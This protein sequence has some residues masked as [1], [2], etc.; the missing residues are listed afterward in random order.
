MPNLEVKLPGLQ[1]SV[2]AIFDGGA[3]VSIISY[4]LYMALDPLT[5]PKLLP[6][7]QRI[8][9]MWSDTHVPVGEIILP[10]TIPGLQCTIEYRFAVEMGVDVPLLL[11]SSFMAHAGISNH[12]GEHE[13]ERKGIRAR[14]ARHITRVV[15]CRRITL[16]NDWFIPPNSRT[17]VPGSVKDLK[18][19]DSEQDALWLVEPTTKPRE[20]CPILVSRSLCK[21][22]QVG[23]QIPVEV[24]NPT[25]EPMQLYRSTTIGLLQQVELAPGVKP[26]DVT[27]GNAPVEVRHTRQGDTPSDGGAETVSLPPELEEMIAECVNLG[28]ADTILFKDVVRRFRKLF[29]LKGEPLGR[30]HVTLHDVDTGDAKPIKCRARRTP[31]GLRDEAMKE[32]ARMLEQGVIEPSESPWASPVV[33]V[34]KKD[35]SLRYCVDYRKLNKVTKKDSYPLPNMQECLDSLG[36]AKYFSTMDLCSGYWQVGMTEAAKVKSA[37]YGVGG[38]L[39]QFRVMPFGLSNAPATFERLMERVLG[40]LQ[41]QICLCYIDDI[42]VYSSTISEHLSRLETVLSRLENANLKLKPKK[43]HFFQSKVTF[44][45]HVVSS[46]GISTDPA[47]V[48]KVLNC[49]APTNVHELRSL[50]GFLS[51]YRRFIPQFTELAKPLIA[52]T[53]KD[54]RFSWGP[55]QEK[56]F[57]K[58]KQALC[59]APVLAYPQADSPFMLDTDASDVG[60]GAVLSQVQ[61]GEERVIAYG[62]RVLTKAERN[63]CVTR[64][65]LLAVVHFTNHYRHFLLGRR[66][67]VRTDNSAVRNMNAMAYEPVGQI[68]R[69]LE[70]LQSFDFVAEHRPG[71]QH[72]NADGMSRPPFVRCADCSL[73]HPGAKVTKRGNPTQIS[74][75]TPVE[76]RRIRT[77]SSHAGLGPEKMGANMPQGASPTQKRESTQKV[78]KAPRVVATAPR[79][80]AEEGSQPGQGILKKARDSR[81]KDSGKK[82]EARKRQSH[83]VQVVQG[84]L[85]RPRGGAALAANSWLSGGVTL[86][87]A[88]LAGEQL[89]DPAAVDARIW[90]QSGTK[91]ARADIMSTSLDHKFLWTN[92]EVLTVVDDV[93]T[94]SIKPKVSGPEQQSAYVPPS[95]RRQVISLCHDTVTSGHF[96]YWKTLHLVKRYFIW[97]GMRKDIQVYCQGCHTCATKKQAGN[98]QRAPMKRYD[99]GLPMEEICIDLK[100]PYPESERGNKYVLVVVDSFTKWMEAYPIPNAE[101][102]TVAEKLVMEFIARFGVPFWIKSDQGRQFQSELFEEMCKLLG[103]EH[104]TSTA[105][106]PQGNSRVERM[107]KVVGNLLSAFC[108]SQKTW[109]DNLPLLTLAYNCT[110]H[111]V[112]GFS[113][114]YMT[115]GREVNLPLDLMIGS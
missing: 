71:R 79:V 110:L 44:L 65:E 38:G 2:L 48:E 39:W 92:Y 61:G 46:D 16:A 58:L 43:C 25:S 54:K 103:V 22:D 10:V 85:R 98:P 28:P 73:E 53:E 50:V 74:Q 23:S 100:G 114:N 60:I 30:T 80:E 18:P 91:P 21:T 20:E 55:D 24:Y 36:Q 1:T 112:T 37:F 82:P 78:P 32:E 5:R 7:Q 52:M 45:G 17:L 101:A 57:T 6:S 9:G 107:V 4:D 76:S 26:I 105:F 77:S 81:G 67:T 111:E 56:S 115:F 102:K 49:D 41:W 11:D 63:Y 31:I 12:F 19:L 83:R 109:D 27:P 33:L 64:R 62:S 59:S 88:L 66:F 14:S 29:A 104:R 8:R 42:L 3:E 72:S 108:V 15:T 113:P 90:I 89:K 51:Y 70:K 69:W 99:A 68:A 97:P 106:H 34:R 94:V 84:R 96:Y 93:L 47:K 87:K 13:L 95:L 40:Q 75:M 35:D 86:D